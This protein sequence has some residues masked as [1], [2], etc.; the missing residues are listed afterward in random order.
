MVRLTLTQTAAWLTLGATVEAVLLISVEPALH[1]HTHRISSPS[2]GTASSDVN[3][4]FRCHRDCQ[5]S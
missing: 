4:Q 3:R 2:T 5:M 1:T